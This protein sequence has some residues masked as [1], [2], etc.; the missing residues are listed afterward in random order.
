MDLSW[1]SHFPKTL[2]YIFVDRGVKFDLATLLQ[3]AQ[4]RLGL[5]GFLV[6]LFVM[7]ASRHFI[8]SEV[9]TA[10]RLLFLLYS[11]IVHLLSVLIARQISARSPAR[12]S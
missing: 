5:P 3:R 8:W 9:E 10:Q 1:K 12:S 6:L 11:A 2:A 7:P 4:A